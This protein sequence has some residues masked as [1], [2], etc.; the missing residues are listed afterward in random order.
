MENS[1]S[2]PPDEEPKLKYDRMGNDVQN[3][4]IKDAVSCIYVHTKF[5]CLGTQ[6]GV[7]HML[8]HE[9]N[10]VSIGGKDKELQA[11]TIA[12]NMISVDSNGDYI[13]S[14]SDDGRVL[15]YGLYS[16]DNAHNISLSRVVKSVALDPYY[17]RSGSGR[18]FL[19]GDNKLTLH[20]KTFLN[21]LRSTVLCECEGYVQAMAWHERFVAWACEAGVRVHDLDARRSLGLIPWE[22]HRSVEEYRCNLLWVAPN[23][24]MIGWVDTIRICVIRKRNPV[25]LQMRDVTE[26]L[27]DPTY[28][29]QTDYFISGL[30][31]LDDQLVLLGV[32]KEADP[33]SGKAQRPVLTIADYKECEFNEVSTDSLNIRGYEEYHCNDYHLDMIIDEKRYFIVSPKDI[34]VASPYDLDDRVGW[35]MEH[36]RYEKALTVLEGAHGGA[37]KHTVAG[38]GD[39]YLRHLLEQSQYEEAAV[40][41]VRICKGDRALWEEHIHKFAD[42]NQLRTIS[43]YLPKTREQAL[44]SHIYEMVLYEYL[45]VDPQGFL[46]LVQEWNPTL[47]KPMVV[48]KAL[49]EHLLTTQVDKNI[50]LEA[51]AL[52]YC[53]ASK[54]D[55]ALS[56]YLK[57]QHKDVFSLIA[58]HNMHS[59]IHNKIVELMTLDL[60]KAIAILLD[61]SRQLLPV[62]VVEK[63][64]EHHQQYLYRYLDAYSKIEPSGHYHGKL[65]SLYALYDREKL[66]PFLKCSDNY[67][68]QE[69]LDVCQS[70]QLHP[71]TVFL[72]GRMGNT[73]EALAIIMDQLND[74][75]QAINFCQEHNDKELWS[76]LI[77]KTVDRPECVTLLLQR[78]GNY[79][80]PRMLIQNIKPGC[81]I[82]ELKESLAKMMCDYHLQ[83]SV[84]EACKAVTLKNYFEL[85]KKLIRVQ[86]RGIAV[87]DDFMCSLCHG[88]IIIKDLANASDLIVYNCRHSFHI[89]CLPEDDQYVSCA[90]CRDI[91]S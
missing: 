54:Y 20:E 10:R 55:K 2:I 7:I 33:E 88:R 22:R 35:L 18:K 62:H 39:M 36:G 61:K 51:L 56:T 82:R 81:E 42:F 86:Q 9:G 38:V 45:R 13:A 75:N 6:W 80:D 60:D 52:L 91:T 17:Y 74:I 79:V 8:D 27:V 76:D 30:G 4:L 63:Q 57:L 11:H 40:L 24:L 28:T 69:A 46:K 21:R 53:H 87:T 72:L 68:I 67:P 89:E 77:A 29:C 14:C 58:K 90:L 49:I 26:Y 73:R 85:H 84:Q 66:L 43:A 65:V 3:I 78:I 34:V 12:V 83:L 23:T 47:Y 19:T 59:A 1:D 15:V 50:Y 70:H 48:I 31:P 44:S 37:C 41:C 25:E 71:E 32:P 64:L 16:D 5:I